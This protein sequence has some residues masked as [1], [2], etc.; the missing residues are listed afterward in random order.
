M[1]RLVSFILFTTYTSL[2]AQN[3][4]SGTVTNA[5]GVPVPFSTIVLKSL[6]NKGERNTAADSTGYFLFDK[7]V[8]G[9]YDIIVSNIGY[10]TF[11]KNIYI[12]TDTTITI[13]LEENGKELNNVNVT[14]VRST[15][16]RTSDRVIYN[17]SNSVMASGSDVLQA[18]SQMQ[19][20]QVNNNQISVAG[21]RTVRVMVNNRLLQLEGEDLV[22]YL[23]SFSANQVMRIELISNPS[24]RYEVDGNAGLINIVTKRNALKGYSGNVQLASKYY[25]PGVSKLYGARPF[26]ELNGSAN[27]T[28]NIDK[29]SFYGSYN[30]VNSRFLE[31]F[32]FDV[33]YPKQ[34]WLQTD[35]GLY[36]QHSFSTIAGVDYKPSSAVTVGISYSGGKLVYKGFDHVRNPFYNAQG[37]VDSLLTTY[38]TYKP[39]ALSAALNAYADIKLDSAG[40]MLSLKADYFNYYRNDISDFESNNY[41]GAGNS[42]PGGTTS[43]F[44]RNNQN[45]IIYTLRAD[46][47]WPTTFANYQFGGKLSFISEYSNAFYY[48]KMDNGD[49]AYDTNLSN[50]FDYNENIQ[51]VYGSANKNIGRWK[52]QA[53][54]RGELTQTKGY[55]FTVHTTTVRNY[56]KLFPSLLVNYSADEKNV[57]SFT[58]GRRITR[59]SFWNLNPF[60]S[61]YTAYSYGEG[62]PYLQ[63]AYSTNAELTHSYKHLLQTGLFVN[64]NQRWFCK[65]YFSQ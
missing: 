22:Q 6:L 34:H 9:N 33:Y 13:L 29:W 60:K 25:M 7:L 3:K 48:R 38:A 21:K 12:N 62:N 30:K 50:E 35:T 16:E 32:Q 55:S 15:I 64:P 1:I 26:G 51:A 11:N 24:A 20:V 65:H 18:M 43:Y 14:G 4:I 2:F 23:K 46:V 57:F 31:G 37:N 44:D 56:F 28:Y 10:A 45:I 63:P 49:L 53:G 47:D 52:L 19:G 54:V 58:A 17:L 8:A 42:K 41:D 59:P 39:V 40:K 5:A 36:T 61:L 27:L